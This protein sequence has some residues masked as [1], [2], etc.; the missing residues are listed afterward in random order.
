MYYVKMAKVLNTGILS[1][2]SYKPSL[3]I[4]NVKLN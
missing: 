2:M 1:E 4:I 3:S